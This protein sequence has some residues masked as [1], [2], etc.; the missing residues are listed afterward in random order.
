MAKTFRRVPFGKI[1]AGDLTNQS[2]RASANLP[3]S[4][5]CRFAPCRRVKMSRLV[6]YRTNKA[7]RTRWITGNRLIQKKYSISRTPS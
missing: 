2:V 3:G 6:G 5:F 1:T 7:A 4:E